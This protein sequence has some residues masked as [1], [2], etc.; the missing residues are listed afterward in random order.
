[1]GSKALDFR[2]SEALLEI[3]VPTFEKPQGGQ[4]QLFRAHGSHQKVGPAPGLI[5][6]RKTRRV[7]VGKIHSY[8][9][10]SLT[11]LT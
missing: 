2:S 8:K 3:E 1:M 7:Q 4:P 10:L 6:R 9:Y 11:T 5:L